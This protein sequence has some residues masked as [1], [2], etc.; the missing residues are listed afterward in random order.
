MHPRVKLVKGEIDSESGPDLRNYDFCPASGP[1]PLLGSSARPPGLMIPKIHR[2]PRMSPGGRWT[3]L[4]DLSKD[5]RAREEVDQPSGG[6]DLPVFKMSVV[7]CE[8]W[9]ARGGCA[10]PSPSFLLYGRN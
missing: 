7:S 10:I 6:A 5:L 4:H 1:K 3:C 2:P 9:N 8:Q